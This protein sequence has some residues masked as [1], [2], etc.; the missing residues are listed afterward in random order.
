M[1]KKKAGRISLYSINDEFITSRIYQS[2]YDRK[3]II[4]IWIK[5]YPHQF[6]YI[7]IKPEL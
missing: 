7:I 2:V 3:K 5:R 4:D 1:I 6:F